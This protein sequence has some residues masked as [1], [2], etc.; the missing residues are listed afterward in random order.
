MGNKNEGICK[1][2]DL[3]ERKRCWFERNKEALKGKEATL[4]FEILGRILQEY[5]LY[6]GQPFLRYNLAYINK[7]FGWKA[8]GIDPSEKAIEYGRRLCIGWIL[9]Q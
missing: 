4:G 8:I 3:G 7:L 1:N 6:G 5:N 9:L 2:R